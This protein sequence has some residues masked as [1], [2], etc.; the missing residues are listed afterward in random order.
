MKNFSEKDQLALGVLSIGFGGTRVPMWLK[1]Y[2]ENGLGGI[3]LFGSNT[4]DLEATENLVKE[5]RHYNPSIVI[6]IDEEGG[7]VTRIYAG[8]GSEQPSA[9]QLGRIDDIDYTRASYYNLGLV[10]NSLG[11]DLTFAP[12]ADI[13]SNSKNPI[14]GIRS[15]GD[16]ADLV[17]RHVA[18]AVRGLQEAGT[19]ASLK[20]FPGH[21]GVLEDSH[22]NLPRIKGSFVDLEALHL[23]PFL[24]G[25]KAGARSVMVGHLIVDSLDSEN[26]AS[27]SARVMR[28]FLRQDLAYDGVI[29]TD[30]LDMGA[31]GGPANIPHSAAAAIRAGAD[32]L[33]LSGLP[34]QSSFVAGSM[35]RIVTGIEQGQID[36]SNLRASTDRI[37]KLR[38][39]REGLEVKSHLD[40][41]TQL[42]GFE[43]FGNPKVSKNFITYRQLSGEP[44]AAAGHIKWGIKDALETAAVKVNVTNSYDA[45]DVLVF[46]DAWRDPAMWSE[47]VRVATFNPDC[48]FI[49]MGW[50]TTEF[51]AKNLIRT[52][53]VGNLTSRAVL[54][55]LLKN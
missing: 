29:I 21:G 51:T 47:V 45:I 4:P 30:A 24:S 19:S 16:R 26:A 49:D 9:A 22:H 5:I 25:I 50:P 42:K 52:F 12:V 27:Q 11:I 31:L 20:H 1:P 41:N 10:L 39:L 3:T 14:V 8:T 23:E 54:S 53:G 34:D 46:R 17:G 38:G 2:L 15:F 55:L 18:A 6:S 35:Q 48:I 28:D 32:F 33:C 36:E 40:L 7:D 37:S 44:T 13:C 43:V